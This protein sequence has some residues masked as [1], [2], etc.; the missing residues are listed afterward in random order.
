MDTVV[1]RPVAEFRGYHKHSLD[2]KNRL[3]LPESY[4]RT[5]ADRNEFNLFYGLERHLYKVSPEGL[6]FENKPAFRFSERVGRIS[7]FV[8]E[9]LSDLMLRDEVD[10]NIYIKYNPNHHKEIMCYAPFDWVNLPKEDREDF[11]SIELLKIESGGRIL[12]PRFMR[13]LLGLD[14][15]IGIYGRG[16]HFALGVPHLH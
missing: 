12:I 2:H 1:I 15:A 4:L 16:D 13:E 3:K 6:F 5:I 9:D 11:T 8:A 10:R 14:R 7:E